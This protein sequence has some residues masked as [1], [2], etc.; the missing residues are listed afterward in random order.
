MTYVPQLLAHDLG[1]RWALGWGPTVSILPRSAATA[2]LAA[3][4]PNSLV[5]L[6]VIES[7]SFHVLLWA[8]RCL[9]SSITKEKCGSGLPQ[10]PL[11]QPKVQVIMWSKGLCWTCH[12]TVSDAG[13]KKCEK[14]SCI[15]QT[16][17]SNWFFCPS[18]VTFNFET[19]L[20]FFY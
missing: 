12:R 10:R 13:L 8:W 1:R 4:I 6:C 18:C 2:A 19:D 20:L 17:T 5:C 14:L 11:V 7:G 15:L 16:N 9:L 3:R